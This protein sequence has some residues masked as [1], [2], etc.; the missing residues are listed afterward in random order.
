MIRQTLMGDLTYHIMRKRLRENA[1]MIKRN[2]ILFSPIEEIP[3]RHTN[4][5][6]RNY[7][8]LIRHNFE[9]KIYY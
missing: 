4:L 3:F 5:P 9:A 8:Y 2:K 7:E 1:W 6:F